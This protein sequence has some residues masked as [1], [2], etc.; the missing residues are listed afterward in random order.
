MGRAFR[1]AGLTLL[2]VLVFA[3]GLISIFQ[4]LNSSSPA[5]FSLGLASGLGAMAVSVLMA[6]LGISTLSPSAPSE[7]ADTV[8]MEPDR[9]KEKPVAS[10]EP[11]G[12]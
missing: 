12:I 2:S 3:G 6:V 1:I 10:L 4:C 9:V 8:G 7:T 11:F 5:D